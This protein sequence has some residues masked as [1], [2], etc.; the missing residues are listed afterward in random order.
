MSATDFAKLIGVDRATLSKWENNADN[1]GGSSDRLIRS[2]ALALGEGLKGRAEE[3]IRN[4][5]WI[6]EEYR[7]EQMNVDMETLEVQT[8]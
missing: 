2:V 1:V 4:F 6:V 3:G 7:S 5:D 8:T